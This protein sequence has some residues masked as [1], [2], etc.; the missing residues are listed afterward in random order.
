M[1]KAFL[2][3]NSAQKHLVEQ[4]AQKV[5]LDYVYMDEFSFQAGNSL[6]M[7]IKNALASSKVFV[8]FLS[9]EAQESPGLT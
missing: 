9:F 6:T 3:H 1:I 5:G 4:V 2:S 8:L 7:E